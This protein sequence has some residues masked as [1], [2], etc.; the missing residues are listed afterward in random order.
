MSVGVGMSGGSSSVHS[1][2]PHPFSSFIQ[3]TNPPPLHSPHQSYASPQLLPL[4]STHWP[5][6]FP[7]YLFD[8]YSAL[9]ALQHA[10]PPA[11]PHAPA[12][13]PLAR[14]PLP[15]P[16]RYASDSVAYGGMVGLGAG[17]DAAV[18]ADM[19]AAAHS[20]LFSSESA[21]ATA[22][23]S[24]ASLLLHSAASATAGATHA[25]VST[26]PLSHAAAQQRASI[27]QPRPINLSAASASSHHYPL[28]SFSSASASSAPA[29]SLP[30]STTS[31]P[32]STPRPVCVRRPSNCVLKLTVHLMELF[33]GINDH[34]Y[35][36]KER[37][38]QEERETRRREREQR[39]GD[40]AV[41]SSRQQPAQHAIPASA[42]AASASSSSS[43]IVPRS[44]STPPNAYDDRDSNYI[45]R[46]Q[47]PLCDGR[48]IVE[49]S[50]GKGSFGR[51][52]QCR[53]LKGGRSVAVKITKSK[54][55]FFKQA[56][57]EIRILQSLQ[58]DCHRFNIVEMVDSF[59]H[60]GHQCFGTDTRVLTDHGFL[61]LS[62]L[63][64]LERDG[65]E[66]AYAAYDKATQQLQYVSGQLHVNAADPN[67]RLVSFTDPSE[68]ARLAA[69]GP[70]PH[71]AG[72]VVSNHVSIRVTPDHDMYVQQ[73]KGMSR[74]EPNH[75]AHR[76][77]K[78]GRLLRDNRAVRF[79]ASATAGVKPPAA[80]FTLAAV[81]KNALNLP[82]HCVD[83][84]LELYGFW[85]GD[86]TLSYNQT[87]LAHTSQHGG[88]DSVQ[89][90]P[91]KKSDNVWLRSQLIACGLTD[92]EHR[93]YDD[94]ADGR[95]LVQVTRRH[96]FEYFDQSYGSKYVYSRYYDSRQALIDQGMHS[97]QRRPS[98]STAATASSSLR[99][100]SDRR[101]SLDS[102]S[103]ASR[104]S[105][106]V[107]VE[108]YEDGCPLRCLECGND[109]ITWFWLDD[110]HET[111]EWHCFRC[112]G[113]CKLEETSSCNELAVSM[114]PT[115]S[116]LKLEKEEPYNDDEDE[117]M[118]D[119]DEKKVPPA[120]PMPPPQ[121]RPRPPQQDEKERP[122]KSAKWL[123]WWVLRLCT[124]E[125]CRLIL[126]G[127]QRADGK[128]ASQENQIYSSSVRFRDELVQLALHGGYSAYFSCDY[129][130]EAIRGYSKIGGKSGR[131]VRVPPTGKE[132]LYKAIK[133]NHD[134]WR[135][136]YTDVRLGHGT[137]WPAVNWTA[138]EGIK[139]EP[140]DGVTWC[141]TVGHRDHLI[142]AQRALVDGDERV[143]KASRP[144]I[145]GQC[146]VFELLS[147]NLYD[148]I[149]NT[150]LTGVTLILTAK[151][152]YQIL[153]TLAHL[154]APSRGDKRVIHCDL[155]PENVLLRSKH[156]SLIKLIDFG[157]ACT[158]KEKAYTY[159][160]S[161]F[162]RAPEVL[163][164]LPYSAP[165]DMWSL[166]CLLMELHTG[167]PL[168]DGA[169]EKEQVL[170]HYEVL[171]CP[172]YDMVHGNSKALQY[173]EVDNT[174]KTARLKNKLTA[175]KVSSVKCELGDKFIAGD[176]RCEQFVDLVK[177]LLTY[178]PKQRIKPYEALSHPFFEI[179]QQHSTNG[180][181]ASSSSSSSSSTSGVGATSGD[182]S[183]SSSVDVSPVADP[184]T[185]IMSV[186]PYVD[187]RMGVL[188]TQPAASVVATFAHPSASSSHPAPQPDDVLMEDKENAAPVPH[189]APPLPLERTQSDLHTRPFVHAP[190]PR[191]DSQ[192]ELPSA[193]PSP[194]ASITAAPA[195][196]A[197]VVPSTIPPVSRE[198]K[199][200]CRDRSSVNSSRNA[201]A[202]LVMSL[203]SRTKQ[204][205]PSPPVVSVFNPFSAL[206]SS[207]SQPSHEEASSN[208]S[209][210]DDADSP[211][212]APLTAVQQP[213]TASA[214]GSRP[215]RI[216]TRS[217]HHRTTS[218]DGVD[219]QAE[220]HSLMLG[221]TDEGGSDN[222]PSTAASAA[223][224]TR[225]G[226]GS[227][228]GRRTAGSKQSNR[229]RKGGGGSKSA[230]SS[231]PHSPQQAMVVELTSSSSDR[232]RTR[233]SRPS[234]A[235][236]IA[237]GVDSGYRTPSP[238][239]PSVQ[240]SPGTATGMQTRSHKA[241]AAPGVSAEHTAVVAM[242][243]DAQPQPQPLVVMSATRSQAGR[244]NS[245]KK[246]ASH[247]SERKAPAYPTFFHSTRRHPHPPPPPAREL[248]SSPR[249]SHFSNLPPASNS[250]AASVRRP[251]TRATA[252]TATPQPDAAAVHDNGGGGAMESVD[253]I[254]RR[255]RSHI[256]MR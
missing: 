170:R 59:M 191:S 37:R 54:R 168:F 153:T 123:L 83:P 148:L 112:A 226:S 219:S 41:S 135:V 211:Q 25:A 251:V 74:M 141:V 55:A 185:A 27:V 200:R 120:L 171:G 33:N 240:Q 9:P 222:S 250:G 198:Q 255:T 253:S 242:E 48:Y 139:E 192:D 125:Q 21:A 230:H 57:V 142:V 80:T 204:S 95:T 12:A 13:L 29:L 107:D 77:I 218:L 188:D 40:K 56:Q 207:P 66:I 201:R 165:I 248:H 52:I 169:D 5:A 4:P 254:S 98:L 49:Q 132:H 206:Q 163:L 189:V 186:Q 28:S 78:A 34:Y 106:A 140:Y 118:E 22:L 97:S 10:Y 32:S 119:D 65:V 134:L 238:A 58:H 237:D 249:P 179:L 92:A 157:S 166:G 70:M 96:W 229:A 1:H 100:R 182:V 235:A 127:V 194:P 36:A 115:A 227:L 154:S 181:S 175:R 86:G 20:A 3:P 150:K 193:Q 164:G 220:L 93:W 180:A 101:H 228:K 236:P 110:D 133:P 216:F 131:I 11:P 183:C 53:D 111:G 44:P 197:A 2:H 147:I 224:V 130:K 114:P 225:R 213:A 122:V 68:A 252:A 247:N 89:F 43:S 94:C 31:A 203:R 199:R 35:A 26:V 208:D 149:R 82:A 8:A 67:G 46:Q 202:A 159:I 138:G 45:V 76:K 99:D 7:Q 109:N 50:L 190:L 64:Q 187:T 15:L 42:T 214:A 145:I 18:G 232:R 256:A 155:K 116:R 117:P 87:A 14:A 61:F 205:A 73:A 38:R 75:E 162:Y 105:C 71:P 195:A 146:I 234:R 19:L 156:R 51:V 121:P 158:I 144:V 178:S 221:V 210:N 161:R 152:A 223:C 103:T 69:P 60:R 85:L 245:N 16:S 233:R 137:V 143:Y 102:S 246:Q 136:H 90:N 6:C 47:E 160:Q 196:P 88:V 39:D 124:A 239:R 30:P 128:W 24:S 72:G 23:S 113:P 172:P 84:F 79:M 177:Q 104:A 241:A 129:T 17:A 167:H 244:A 173:Y 174:R 151:F 231:R 212:P 126:R 176:E 215:S 209:M 184:V 108:D 62:Q 81:L 63:Q 243:D 91:R 217:Q